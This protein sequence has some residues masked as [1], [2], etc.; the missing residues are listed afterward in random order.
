MLL[1]Y[2]TSLRLNYL[3][4][5]YI[6]KFL[7]DDS[8]FITN[9]T[10]HSYTSEQAKKVVSEELYL[11]YKDNPPNGCIDKNGIRLSDRDSYVDLI[12]NVFWPINE[13]TIFW[14]GEYYTP[15]LKFALSSPLM[16]YKGK[17]KSPSVMGW[18]TNYMSPG[19]RLY[20]V[21]CEEDNKSY[22]KYVKDNRVYTRVERKGWQ[23][24]DF[25]IGDR[26]NPFFHSVYT[27]TNRFSIGISTSHFYR[28]NETTKFE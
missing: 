15:P 7:K 4:Q 24:N 17:E 3:K 1:S 2:S 28:E 27:E 19:R 25:M 11:E 9:E 18:H 22:F 5:N 8:T 6:D 23:I 10:N 16:W 14:K 26:D 13:E 21:W 12:K 20:F